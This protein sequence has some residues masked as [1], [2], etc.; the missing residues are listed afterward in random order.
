MKLWICCALLSFVALDLMAEEFA[1]HDGVKIHYTVQGSGTPVLLIHGLRGNAAANWTRPG[2]TAALAQSHRVIAM[3][4]RGH[5]DSGKP[6]TEAEYGVAMVEDVIALL[7][8]LDIRKVRLVGYSM[9]GMIS[10]KTAVLHPERV[11]SLLLCGMGWLQE[12]GKQQDFWE[13]VSA[14]PR[15][16]GGRSAS[17]CMRG[18]ARLAVTEAQLKTLK[19]PAAVIVGSLDPVDRLYVAPLTKARPEWPVTRIQGAGHI[20]CIFKPDFTTAVVSSVARMDGRK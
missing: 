9:G 15:L 17:A 5:G 7:N 13:G 11:H 2:I 3:D 8:R 18:M 10:L 20:S 1:S 4:A 19:M 16:I 14:R 6:V 12:G